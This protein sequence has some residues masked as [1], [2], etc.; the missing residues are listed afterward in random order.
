V[1]ESEARVIIRN[2]YRRG[3][4]RRVPVWGPWVPVDAWFKEGLSAD[5]V[6][7]EH[8]ETLELMRGEAA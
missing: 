4:I 8:R 3:T 6:S 5:P 2:A 7:E 1:T